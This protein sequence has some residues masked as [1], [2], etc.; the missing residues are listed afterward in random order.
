MPDEDNPPEIQ[1][2]SIETIEQLPEAIQPG[3]ACFT[4]LLA[5]D[6]P[7]DPTQL[8]AWMRPVVERGL[9]CFCA[10]GEGCEAVHD[11]VDRC[12]VAMLKGDV[13]DDNIIMTTW[14]S[15]ESLAEALWY[16]AH[17]AEPASARNISS[18][19]RFAIAVDNPAW[20]EEMRTLLTRSDF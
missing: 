7:V 2:R 5:W 14:H 20:A 6:A 8:E 15:D 3:N 9:V 4:L 17:C 10:W 16:L 18:F 19:D 12:A 1:V 13:R 11:A